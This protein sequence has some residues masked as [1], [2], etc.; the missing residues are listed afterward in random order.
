MPSVARPTPSRFAVMAAFAAVYVI[1]GSTYLAIRIAVET[2]PPFLMAG[3]RFLTA[4]TILYAWL[5]WRGVPAPKRFHWRPALIVG[6]LLLLG[7]NGG[8]VWAEQ[9]GKVPSGI[10]AL[11][12]TAVPMWMVLL[13]WLRRGGVR[14]TGAEVLGLVVGFAGV[15]IL[16]NPTSLSDHE[17][18]DR[19]GA[20]VLILA[21][22][23]WA[24][25]SLY[26]RHAKLPDSPLLAT[27][28]EMLTGGALLMVASLA[29]G[30]WGRFEPAKV[31]T[32]SLLALA[33]LVVFGALIGLTAY[34]W[35]LQV[36]TPAKASTYAYVNPVIAVILGSMIL[37]EPLTTT[38]VFAMTVILTGVVLITTQGAGKK[39]QGARSHSEPP[40]PAKDEVCSTPKPSRPSQ[41][42][43]PT[44]LTAAMC[45]HE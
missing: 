39:V 33:Y 22:F 24:A 15:A 18:V 8:V 23:C 16:I 41:T 17:P 20:A 27:A 40:A 30:E 25:G 31:S 3:I 45:Q 19:V 14:P 21:S 12:V 7:G 26:S 29:T 4:G 36:S 13:N 44:N 32:E 38:T 1:W 2:T 11:L 34:I 10:A 42:E 28:M 35:I 6:G 5:R 9:P 43:A 37:D